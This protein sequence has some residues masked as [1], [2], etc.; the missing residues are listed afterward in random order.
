M[1]IAAMMPNATSHAATHTIAARQRPR[2][3]SACFTANTVAATIQ[4]D[5]TANANGATAGMAAKA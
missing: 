1:P 2:K 5:A 4:S 3:S